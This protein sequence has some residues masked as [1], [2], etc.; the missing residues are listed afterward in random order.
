MQREAQYPQLWRFSPTGTAE[1]RYIV[2]QGLWQNPDYL[3]GEITDP[4]FGVLI[5][6]NGT[7]F[8]DKGHEIGRADPFYSINAPEQLNAL[9]RAVS[10]QLRLGRCQVH[11]ASVSIRNGASAE[12]VLDYVER[13]KRH[14][15][16]ANEQM[17]GNPDV[18]L[19][20]RSPAPEGAEADPAAG[21]RL[22]EIARIIEDVDNRC[23]A[24]DG[25]VTKTRHEMT[26]DEMRA[27]YALAKDGSSATPQPDHTELLP[28]IKE[29]I[30]QLRD[31]LNEIDRW[32]NGHRRTMPFFSE[33]V[34]FAD[35][36]LID[37]RE[38]HGN[39]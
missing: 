2:V 8:T 31:R 14:L 38:V 9:L 39:D 28:R 33:A 25:P 20:A 10:D 30:E 23:L 13:A 27:I 17:N 6:R 34:T 18:V 3:S 26:D 37:I 36:V 7:V 4:R 32:Q 24:A 29:C 21:E 35:K 16:A 1:P 22:A 11:D 5:W 12:T 19:A 15:S